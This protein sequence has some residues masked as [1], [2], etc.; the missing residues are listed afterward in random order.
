MSFAICYRSRRPAQLC[1][2]F[3]SKPMLLCAF[4]P[5]GTRA[6]GRTVAPL[7]A[8]SSSFY[9]WWAIRRSCLA[10]RVVRSRISYFAFR[11]GRGVGRFTVSSPASS[12]PSKREAFPPLR[13]DFGKLLADSMSVADQDAYEP[14]HSS[15]GMRTRRG[16]GVR[17]S[18]RFGTCRLFLQ[19]LRKMPGSSR[20]LKRSCEGEVCCFTT[21]E[22]PRFRDDYF[23]WRWLRGW[24]LGSESP[25]RKVE[26]VGRVARSIDR[27]SGLFF[28]S[29]FKFEMP[30][31]HNEI[32]QNNLGVVY[33]YTCPA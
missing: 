19:G 28:P 8:A 11:N 33:A 6:S 24:P 5:S 32:P 31:R 10:R 23:S 1:T 20:N 29:F 13:W 16:I 26:A 2:N 22:F 21:K 14:T 25:S 4:E 18:Q 30:T 9:C 7:P 17:G 15:C 3:N 27:L 12:S